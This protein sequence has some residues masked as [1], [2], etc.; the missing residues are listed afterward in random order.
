MYKMQEEKSRLHQQMLE[1][2][3]QLSSVQDQ[4]AK[5]TKRERMLTNENIKLSSEIDHLK[6]SNTLY[7][8]S[9]ILVFPSPMDFEKSYLRKKGFFKMNYA[10]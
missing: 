10:H 8:L 2:Q 9:K 4:L 5:V 1:A 7:V 6:L 3:R